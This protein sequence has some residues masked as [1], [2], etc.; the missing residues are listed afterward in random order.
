MS[1]ESMKIEKFYLNKQKLSHLKAMCL[2]YGIHQ[3]IFLNDNWIY[4]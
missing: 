3:K 4:L 1:S 2:D